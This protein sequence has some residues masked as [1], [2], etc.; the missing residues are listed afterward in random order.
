[1][2][3][4]YPLL[5]DLG[6]EAVLVQEFEI[7]D[8]NDNFLKRLEMPVPNVLSNVYPKKPD[9]KYADLK[10]FHRVNLT[11]GV[12]LYFINIYDT[13]GIK[14]K[15]LITDNYD[16]I[17]PV[18]FLEKFIDQINPSDV[19]I[20]RISIKDKNRLTEV[21]ES[22]AMQRV[23]LTIIPATISKEFITDDEKSLVG[24][25][26]GWNPETIREN[27]RKAEESRKRREKQLA[28]QKQNE[29]TEPVDT[30]ETP[31]GD[32]STTPADPELI[33]GKQPGSENQPRIINGEDIV[34]SKANQGGALEETLSSTETDE[35]ITSGAR[36]DPKKAVDEVKSLDDK[37]ESSDLILDVS[38]DSRKFMEILN[39]YRVIPEP[40][41][42]EYLR[43]VHFKRAVDGQI[44]ISVS[45]ITMAKNL[46]EIEEIKTIADEC[47][48]KV[49]EMKQKVSIKRQV[50]YIERRAFD[51]GENPYTGSQSCQECHLNEFAVWSE[52][53]HASALESLVAKGDQENESCLSCHKTQWV[54]PAA[55]KKEWT[56]DTY[57][58]ELGCESCHGPGRA[59]LKLIEF[60]IEG[61]RIKHW[62][63]IKN[64][65]PNLYLRDMLVDGKST[66]LQCHDKLNSP[67]FDFIEY[68]DMIEH[69]MSFSDDPLMDVKTIQDQAAPESENTTL[70][71]PELQRLSSGQ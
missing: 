31:N 59:H 6:V 19:L 13:Q 25:T 5:D 3:N 28:L 37:K 24:V 67:D 23:D 1:M 35:S 48:S 68:W 18:E 36:P 69:T 66:C 52:S 47:D 11:N 55:Y 70:P 27:E 49:N 61:D 53:K 17:E 71:G 33:K 46:P 30:Q 39:E 54:Q 44:E 15:P 60:A 12:D 41:S 4:M 20:A 64:E 29:T 26:T 10:Q 34:N 63:Y 58:P 32:T 65:S 42:A 21:I 62:D 8:K 16:I 50:G 7:R 56:F 14:Q 43:E 51:T 40:G 38:I 2:E 22:D 9:T 57:A 45:D